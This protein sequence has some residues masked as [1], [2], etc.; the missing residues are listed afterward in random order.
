MK[1]LTHKSD[2]K[3]LEKDVKNMWRWEWLERDK[4]ELKYGEW[5]R[6]P[7]T[8]GIAFCEEILFSGNVVMA[9]DGRTWTNLYPSAF[10][11]G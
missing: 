4:D 3:S 5:L 2:T 9:P 6:K 11:R 10:G 8:A 1:F 7:D